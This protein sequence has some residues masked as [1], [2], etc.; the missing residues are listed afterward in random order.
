MAES[1][2]IDIE[3]ETKSSEKAHSRKDGFNQ[4]ITSLESIFL[5]SN[6]VLELPSA[7]FDQ[8]SSVHKPQFALLSMLMSFTVL[9][10]SVLDLVYKGKRERVSLMKKGLLPWFY[11]PYP[12]SKP[13]GTFP[14]IIGL[15]CAFFQWIFAS[16]AFAFLSRHT[17]NPVKVSTWPIFFAFGLLY[18]KLS[19]NLLQTR[20][21]SN[22][23]KLHREEEF[24]LAE[25]AAAT[26]D[27]SDDCKLGDGRFG[28]V[29]KGRL[30]DG[31]EVVIKRKYIGQHKSIE[32]DSAYESELAYF[33]R[34]HHKHLVR[35]V[36]YCEQE[37]ERLAVFEYMANGSLYHQLFHNDSRMIDSWVM[38][39]RIAL[40]A[41]RGIDYL[42]NYA[43]PPIIHRAINSSCILLDANW[44]A[45]I[46]DFGLMGL[47]SEQ[48]YK[49][50]MAAKRERD[51]YVD[52]EYNGENVLTAKS[53]V[54]S[55]GVVLLELLTGKMAIFDKETNL[56][57]FSVP[58]ILG[59]E[60]PLILD[61]RID[62]PESVNEAEAIEMV[63]YTA[64]HCVNSD[65]INRPTITNIV[66]NLEQA[67]SRITEE[68]NGG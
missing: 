45:R 35:V 16:I 31:R 60:L 52:P 50:K 21:A 61:P 11:C 42:H 51:G 66:N 20:S 48:E 29:Y 55:F 5:V 30:E 41:A 38:R 59:N 63:A 24:T 27:F 13:F 32:E 56:V 43:V 8:L 10:I 54:Y 9:V 64:L 2:Q 28:I 46:A 53:D 40:D 34:L 39:I 18:T 67:F 3:Q 4:K 49:S 65:G 68:S 44:T 14:D 36:G 25:L 6:F 57:Q 23:R 15:V 58:K 22:L 7:V 47:E 37:T 33:L 1:L 17:D 62:P 19:G 12:N 26:Y